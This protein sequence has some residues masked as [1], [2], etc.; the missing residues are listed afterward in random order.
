MTESSKKIEIIQQAF[1]VFYAHGFHAAGIDKLLA[2]S[3][4]SKRT[5]YKYFRTKEDLISATINYYQE[6]SLN[7][8]RTELEKRGNSAKEKLLALFDIRKEALAAGDFSGCFAINANLEYVNKHPEIEA[9]CAGFLNK[10]QDLVSSLCLEMGYPSADPIVS[11]IMILLEGVIV[12]GQSK[13][14]PAIALQAKEMVDM[15]ICTSPKCLNS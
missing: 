8:L 3:G 13:R 10:L 9:A 6:K 14:D 2:D 1:K 11:K 12:Y 5:L 15:L 4:I 7:A